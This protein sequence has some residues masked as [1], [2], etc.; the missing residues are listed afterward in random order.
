[1]TSHHACVTSFCVFFLHLSTLRAM[2][3]HAAK[4]SAQLS[5]IKGTLAAA[6]SWDIWRLTCPPT[7]TM[8]PSLHEQGMLF[9]TDKWATLCTRYNDG[10]YVTF[11]E[12][13]ATGGCRTFVP[14]STP[15]TMTVFAVPK[16]LLLPADF[17]HSAHFDF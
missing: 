17:V 15:G 7:L 4:L 3:Q 1:M 14:R 12:I 6:I 10:H 16:T 8:K 5:A 13:D 11:S 2:A 9:T